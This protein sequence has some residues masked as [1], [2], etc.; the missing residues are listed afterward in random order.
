MCGLERQKKAEVGETLPQGCMLLGALE[1]LLGG[2]FP[3]LWLL[4]GRRFLLQQRVFV[5]VMYPRPDRKHTGT[6]A[7]AVS[8]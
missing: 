1:R 7:L 2:R 6:T 3:F 8:Y 5:H 4:L